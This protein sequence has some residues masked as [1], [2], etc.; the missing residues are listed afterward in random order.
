[1]GE[2]VQLNFAPKN[3]G[4]ILPIWVNFSQIIKFLAGHWT[5]WVC[6]LK[7][8]CLFFCACLIRIEKRNN[9]VEEKISIQA[10]FL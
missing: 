8:V 1:M 10:F 7:K 2:S 9:F 4:E 6:F 5:K 3:S